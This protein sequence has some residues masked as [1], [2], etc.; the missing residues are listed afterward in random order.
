MAAPQKSLIII[1]QPEQIKNVLSRFSLEELK[2]ENH[3]L[4]AVFDYEAEIELQKIEVPHIS[5]DAWHINEDEREKYFQKVCEF[6]REWY[7]LPEMKIFEYESIHLGEILEPSLFFYLG[8]LVYWFFHFQKIFESNFKIKEIWICKSKAF[9]PPTSVPLAVFENALPVEIMVYLG[10]MRNVPV[11]TIEI[12][13]KAAIKNKWLNLKRKIKKFL[14]ELF[15]Y[16]VN[17]IVTC[18]VRPKKIKIFASEYWWHIKPF[19][20]KMKDVELVMMDRKEIFDMGWKS[21]RFRA[22]F[23]HPDSFLTFKIRRLIKEKQKYFKKNLNAIEKLAD[24]SKK[25]FDN[26]EM[27]VWPIIKPVLFYWIGDYS[28]KILSDIEG[29]KGLLKYFSINRVLVRASI[30][31]Q[32]HF[33]IIPRIAKNLKI[34][35]VELQHALEDNEK[36]SVFSRLNSQYL[37]G[38]GRLTKETYVRNHNIDPKRIIEIGS[39][40]FDAYLNARLNHKEKEALF[41]KLNLSPERPIILFI[42]P[43]AVLTL[44]RAHYDTYEVKDLFAKISILQ[45]KIK[46]LQFILKL[47]PWPYY[48]NFYKKIQKQLLPRGAVISHYE[49]VRNLI[50]ISNLVISHN[51]TTVVE[52]IILE[53]PVILFGLRK[54]DRNFEDFEKAGVLFRPED[55]KEFID[56]VRLLLFDKQRQHELLNNIHIFLKNNYLFD[57]KSSQ[58]IASF[59]D[60]LSSV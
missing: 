58:R 57:G 55:N 29:V 51:S 14:T 50:E 47:R 27:P 49:D 53:K 2:S 6:S 45:K 37:A 42:V 23:F 15:F 26:K 31:L 38:Y 46:G 1:Y 48:L 28:G 9:I 5:L 43:P 52:A 25:I 24:F 40:R 12:S 33:F 16:F 44:S 11:Y 4:I 59:L 22:R 13:S 3:Y 8:G 21:F 20:E 34:S 10:R 17:F 36:K 32:P 39:P 60:S 41:E 30:S 18:V 54:A 56:D 7:R 35:A 19:M